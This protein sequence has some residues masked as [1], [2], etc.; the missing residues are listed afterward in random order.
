MHQ[1]HLKCIATGGP[2]AG[3]TD[4]LWKGKF[5]MSERCSSKQSTCPCASV[6]SLASDSS[7]SPSSTSISPVL[8]CKCKLIVFLLKVGPKENILV[9]LARCVPSRKSSSRFFSYPCSVACQN[10]R[11]HALWNCQDCPKYL[12]WQNIPNRHYKK[13]CVFLLIS[14]G[15]WTTPFR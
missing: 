1:N 5:L 7:P 11:G 6:E 2:T 13:K 10:E 15:S 12:E 4:H 14:L 3:R 9:N 8:K